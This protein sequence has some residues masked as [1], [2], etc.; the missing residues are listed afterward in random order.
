MSSCGE[1][2]Y[3]RHFRGKGDVAGGRQSYYYI[4]GAVVYSSNR[5]FDNK[6]ASWI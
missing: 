4:L 3:L 5:T 2:V 1:A 6:A